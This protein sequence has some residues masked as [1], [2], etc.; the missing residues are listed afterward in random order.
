MKV[1]WTLLNVFALGFPISKPFQKEE[2]LYLC[3]IVAI[4]MAFGPNH[5]DLDLVGFG[6]NNIIQG[7]IFGQL[8]LGPKHY[9]PAWPI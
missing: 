7:I 9:D 2:K 6:P 5:L 4:M 8:E 3:S 1:F